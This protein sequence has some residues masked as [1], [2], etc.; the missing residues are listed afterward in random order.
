MLTAERSKGWWGHLIAQ[1]QLPL[2]GGQGNTWLPFPWGRRKGK[3]NEG[4]IWVHPSS[5]LEVH[6]WGGCCCSWMLWVCSFPPRLPGCHCWV[7]KATPL[8]CRRVLLIGPTLTE[9]CLPFSCQASA[10]CHQE[11]CRAL[12]TI[13]P[14][15][16]VSHNTQQRSPCFIEEFS[17]MK[18]RG[19]QLGRLWRDQSL[20]KIG[21]LLW[22]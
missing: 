17:S 15:C 21:P 18:H 6:G 13:A 10:S 11:V 3:R 7:F 20:R 9:G 5:H 12:E 4:D 16:S 8:P 14:E 1:L 2:K 19:W 22:Y